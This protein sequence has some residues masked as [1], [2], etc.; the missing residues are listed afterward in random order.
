LGW[1]HYRTFSNQ[2]SRLK[3]SYEFSFWKALKFQSFR[4][5]VGSNPRRQ[6]KNIYRNEIQNW[7]LNLCMNYMVHV[8]STM[9][10]IK[11]Q[12]S[13]SASWDDNALC[14][15]VLVAGK[16]YWRLQ[17]TPSFSSWGCVLKGYFERGIIFWRA[18]SRLKG[19]EDFNLEHC[20]QLL[21][22]FDLE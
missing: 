1:S 14:L 18:E 10:R 19:I 9:S 17:V 12:P 7:I 16:L 22:S 11:N 6:S 8:S 21:H 4:W 20:F 3:P 15:L 2:C 13:N 5:R